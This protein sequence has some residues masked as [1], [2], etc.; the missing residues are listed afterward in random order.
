MACIMASEPQPPSWQGVCDVGIIGCCQAKADEGRKGAQ[1]VEKR[2]AGLA[3]YRRASL[4]V[5][6]PYRIPVVHCIER[7]HFVHP[8]R[9]HLQQARHLIHHADA[10]EPE[11]ALAE[12][13][14]RH[15]GCFFV[16][17]RVPL[18]DLGDEFLVD[19]VE[20]EGVLGVVAG[21]VAVLWLG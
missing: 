1:K 17:G 6:P 18:Q 9:R 12:I 11:L 16:L 19:G 7:R 21:G 14:E 15:H 10:R 5:K 8:H 4:D 20:G 2:K 13:E 3:T